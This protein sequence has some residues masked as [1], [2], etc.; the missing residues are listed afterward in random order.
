MTP[1]ERFPAF[2]E[3][4]I[5]AF[6]GHDLESIL[7]HYA[8][9]VAFHSPFVVQLGF[10]ETGVICTKEELRRYFTRGLQAYPDL[11]FQVHEVLTGLDSLVIHYT[12]VNNLL[13]AETFLLNAQG[14]AHTVYCH[15]TAKPVAS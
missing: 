9:P 3:A 15:Y 12:S 6:N 14:K 8:D 13:A 5:R 2:A 7:E 1:N 10:N 11:H 4:W